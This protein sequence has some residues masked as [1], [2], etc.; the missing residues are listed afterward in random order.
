MNPKAMLIVQKL[1]LLH[2]LIQQ[3]VSCENDTELEY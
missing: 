3:T 2:G 1:Q